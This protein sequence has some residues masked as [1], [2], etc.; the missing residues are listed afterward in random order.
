MEEPLPTGKLPPA[1]LRELLEE[2][3]EAPP[4]VLLGPRLGEDAC[5]IRVPGGTLV[6]ATDP[7]TLTGSGV[8]AHS[9]VINA[10]DVAVMGVRPRWFLAAVLFPAGTRASQ[11]RTC[12]RQMRDATRAAGVALVGGHTEVTDAVNQTVVVGQMLGLA[13]D[14][15]FVRTGGARP[16]DSI[17]QVGPAPVEGAA[18]LACEAAERARSSRVLSLT[19]RSP[20]IT[21]QWPW[22]VYSQRQTSVTTITSGSSDLR[23]RTAVCTAASSSQA[24]EPNSSFF[25]GRPKRITERTPSSRAAPTSSTSRSTESW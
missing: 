13:A 6:A 14:G 22:L 5:A 25:S 10:N 24:S 9:V 11:V 8:G 7:I 17:V 20:S 12:F 19:T 4:E 16:G 1:L 2:A 3:D 15:G 18:V 21:P 23:R